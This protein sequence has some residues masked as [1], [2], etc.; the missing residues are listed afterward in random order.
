[1]FIWYFYFYPGVGPHHRHH[2]HQH[3]HHHHYFWAPPSSIWLF[4]FTRFFTISL[5]TLVAVVCMLLVGL[6]GKWLGQA[7]LTWSDSQVAR[8]VPGARYLEAG[9]LLPGHPF[10]K[11]PACLSYCHGVALY[12]DIVCMCD[13][14]LLVSFSFACAAGATRTSR[15][16]LFWESSSEISS[17]SFH[18]QIQIQRCK[19]KSSSL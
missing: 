14:F 2:H 8:W 5:V 15:K 19:C 6:S 9:Y 10:F 12:I 11:V 4:C 1:M 3:H 7:R 16:I 17:C 18:P 13:D